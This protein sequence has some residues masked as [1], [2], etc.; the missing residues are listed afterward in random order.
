MLREKAE[1]LDA[2]AM[3]RAITRISFEILEKNGGTE[4]LCIVGIITRGGYLAQRI[5]Q[6]LSEVEGRQVSV[7]Y[8]D[9]TPF[10]D[11]RPGCREYQDRSQ[12]EF[13]IE[14]AKV[15]L[16][17]DVIFTGRSVRAAI[18]ALMARGRPQRIQLAALVDRGHRELPI[19]ADF[20]GKNL[21]TSREEVVKVSFR[22]RDG[23]DRVAIYAREGD[24]ARS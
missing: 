5:A 23:I 16:V 22:E 7:G 2:K 9:I 15:V 17:D 12:L 14:D 11:D 20:I 19:R 13:P 3:T 4:N 6:K 1:I 18:D 21:P 24:P 10:R 8:L